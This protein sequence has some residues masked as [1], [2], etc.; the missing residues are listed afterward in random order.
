MTQPLGGK[1]YASKLRDY[2]ADS[3]ILYVS[4]LAAGLGSVSA[5][6]AWALLEMIALFTN[7]FYFH[8]WS[9]VGHDPWQSGVHWWSP[10]MPV[11]GGLLV[12][13]IAR[14]LS[15]RVRGHGMPEAIET[16]VFGGGK[17]QPR[18]AILKPVATAIAIGSGGPFGAEGPV[19]IT[20]GAIGSVLGQLLPMTGSERTVLMVAGASAGMAATFNCPMSATLLA[21]EILLFEWR[22]RSL[23][24]VAIACVTASAVRRLLLGP[25]PLL[26]MAPTGAPIYHSAILCALI[27]GIVAAFV[28]AGLSKAVHFSE[29][30][31]AK[32]PIHWMWWP[33]IGGLGIGLGGLVFPKALGV[34]YSTIQEMITGDTAWKLLAGI[35]VIKSLIWVFS[36]GSNTAG[37]ILAPLLMIGGALGAVMGHLAPVMSQGAWVLVGMASVLTGAIGCPLTSA[38]LALELTHNGGLMLPVLLA[39]VAAYAVSVLVMPRSMLTESLSQRGLHLSREFGVDPLETMLASQAMHTSVFALSDDA[40]RKDAFDWLSKM[41][42]RGGEAWSHWQRVFPLVD[43][44]E[45]L[46]GLLTRSQM[47]TAA[48][49]ADLSQPLVLSGSTT[50]TTVSPRNTLRECAVMMAETKLTAFPVVNGEGKLVGIITIDDL[51]KGRSE[52]ARRESDRERVLRLRWPFGGRAVGQSGK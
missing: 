27:L 46:T 14:Y 25:Q 43:A 39:S 11:L 36:L 38:M 49:Q 24:P 23:V 51:L 18:V 34:G 8:R 4:V 33:A 29:A 2:S 22:P 31:F 41:E 16:I 42:E 15:P 17:V 45:R 19:I 52:Q 10:L 26:H 3:R 35:L 1:S 40:T 32:L 50:P 9:F 12:G 21:V 47:M 37:S 28:A 44:E 48:K 20:G 5:V 7:L 30:M 13:L 6:A